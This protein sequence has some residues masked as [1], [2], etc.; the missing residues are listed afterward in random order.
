MFRENP[1]V[2]FSQSTSLII[3]CASLQSNKVELCSSIYHFF[4]SRLIVQYLYKKESTCCSTEENKKKSHFPLFSITL[5]SVFITTRKVST[6]RRNNQ[7][8]IF[9]PLCALIFISLIDIILKLFI[10]TCLVETL[11]FQEMII[12]IK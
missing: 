11:V 9:V 5:I 7:V 6:P 10:T 1:V 8:N 4:S 12:V 2:Q 3:G